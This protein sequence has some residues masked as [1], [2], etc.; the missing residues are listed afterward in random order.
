MF[1]SKKYWND[2][3]LTVGNSGAGSYNKLAQFKADIINNFVEKNQ[4]IN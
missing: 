3:Y 1:N 2:R 4:I